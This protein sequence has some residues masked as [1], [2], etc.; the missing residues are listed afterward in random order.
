[1][2][3]YFEIS[4]KRAVELIDDALIK[5]NTFDE[6]LLQLKNKYK[7]DKEH[8][9]NSL[10]R[11]LEFSNLWFKNYPMHLDC[12]KEFK[13]TSEKW[14]DGWEIRPRKGNKKFYAEFIKGMEGVNYNDLKEALFGGVIKA[15]FS[16]EYTKVN[17]KYFISCSEMI[18]L[19]H[20][21]ITASQ[22]KKSIE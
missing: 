16:L 13:I 17:D 19:P 8:V 1:M 10:D 22:Y 11:G 12:E 21:E 15:R 2:K 14:K 4:T 20:K 6:K 18:L 9:F 3:F 7:S 5:I